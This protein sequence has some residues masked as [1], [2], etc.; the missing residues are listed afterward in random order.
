MSFL[1][2]LWIIWTVCGSSSHAAYVMNSPLNFSNQQAF[3]SFGLGAG[4]VVPQTNAIYGLVQTTV[5][6]HL[7]LAYQHGFDYLP[8][9][10]VVQGTLAQIHGFSVGYHQFFSDYGFQVGAHREQTAPYSN[11]AYALG[12]SSYNLYGLIQIGSDD[13]G[14]KSADPPA[15]TSFQFT[16]PKDTVLYAGFRRTY[17]DTYRFPNTGDNSIFQFVAGTHASGGDVALGLG[18]FYAEINLEMSEFGYGSADHLFG[19][20]MGFSFDLFG[21]SAR[22]KALGLNSL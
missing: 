10:T 11:A 16:L 20:N 7:Q 2:G 17:F 1:L 18:N 21:P 13:V 3:F 19:M 9:G 6:N 22:D 12:N 15:E 8:Q 14:A 4:A 5:L